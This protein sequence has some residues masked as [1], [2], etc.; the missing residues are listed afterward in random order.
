M[1]THPNT[2]RHTHSHTH[3]HMHTHA[4]AHTRTLAHTHTHAHTHAYA[5]THTHAQTHS[6]TQAHTRTHTHAQKYLLNWQTGTSF[7]HVTCRL[8]EERM[9][10]LWHTTMVV[11]SLDMQHSSNERKGIIHHS[12]FAAPRHIDSFR[13]TLQPCLSRKLQGEEEVLTVVRMQRTE[14]Y[15]KVLCV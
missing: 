1:H 11:V 13:C 6:H 8:A 10:L 3:T 7:V 2:H 15:F 4:Y 5:H 12:R 9:L 14:L